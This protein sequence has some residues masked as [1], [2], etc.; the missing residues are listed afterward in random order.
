MPCLPAARLPAAQVWEPRQ[1]PV[2]PHG[3][4]CMLGGVSLWDRVGSLSFL[5]SFPCLREASRGC[6]LGLKL[7]TGSESRW[8]TLPHG[9]PEPGRVSKC[10]RFCKSQRVLGGP[11]GLRVVW[12]LLRDMVLKARPSPRSVPTE[13]W[14]G[15]LRWQVGLWND[16]LRVSGVVLTYD[17]LLLFLTITHFTAITHFRL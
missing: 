3:V 15:H 2:G 8:P 16:S 1:I 17:A 11:G 13:F 10:S 6:G 7:R 4:W 5:D 12:P 14:E 9:G